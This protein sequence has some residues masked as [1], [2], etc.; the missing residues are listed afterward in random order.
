MLM[1]LRIGRHSI[2]VKLVTDLVQ[3]SEQ[4]FL[5][6]DKARMTEKVDMIVFI[7]LSEAV[8]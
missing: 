1:I 8:C 2:A 5:E 3:L 7:A 6:L 4:R